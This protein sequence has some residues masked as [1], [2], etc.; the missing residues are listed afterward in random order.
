MKHHALGRVAIVVTLLA[1]LLGGTFLPDFVAA[2]QSGRQ[3]PKK[4]VEKKTEEQKPGEQPKNPEHQ[5]PQDPAPPMPRDIKDQPAIRIS[6]QVVGVD[7]TVIDKKTGRL[8]P[9]LTQKNFTVYEDNV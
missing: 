4:K 9:N 3:P 8:I 7:A 6:T 5:D 2:A 1:A